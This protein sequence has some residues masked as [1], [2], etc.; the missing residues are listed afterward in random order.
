MLTVTICSKHMREEMH[1]DLITTVARVRMGVMPTPCVKLR[2]KKV[3]KELG[4]C[5]RC[6]A[7][8]MDDGSHFLLRCDHKPLADV[9]DKYAQLLE[10]NSDLVQLLT[11][12]K[13]MEVATFFNECYEVVQSIGFG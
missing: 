5:T 8:V 3:P 11:C 10:G 9:R 13:Y 7:Q 12:Q 4:S 6:E 1:P 2:W